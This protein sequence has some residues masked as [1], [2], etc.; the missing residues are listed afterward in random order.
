[1]QEKTPGGKR[2]RK[3]G[4]FNAG[5]G[6]EIFLAGAKFI[7]RSKQSDVLDATVLADEGLGTVRRYRNN[8]LVFLQGEPADALFY[9]QD[10]TVKLSVLSRQGNEA[11][12][13]LLK[14]GEF[15]GEGCLRAERALYSETATS[16]TD[17]CVLRIARRNLLRVLHRMHPLLATL[18][19][20][21]IARNRRVQEDLAYQLFNSAEK[22]LARILLLLAGLD[23][24]GRSE[25]LI[26]N[27]S[28]QILAEMI[29][30]TRQRVNFFM[31]RFRKLGFIEYDHE[32]RVH[33]SLQSVLLRE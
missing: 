28:Q 22:R 8:D 2:R 32:I 11:T 23:S 14:G 31:N 29:G 20:F 1:M 27:V 24:G 4:P 19:S 12:I 26:P 15:F 9:V 10:G 16:L 18:I 33:Q 21:L 17:C 30:V 13:A 6:S 7:R 5:V 25:G 3:P